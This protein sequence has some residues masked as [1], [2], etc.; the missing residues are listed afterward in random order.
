MAHIEKQIAVDASLVRSDDM[1]FLRVQGDGMI[2]AHIMDGDLALIRPREMVEQGAI[3][4]VLIGDEATI[5]YFFKERDGIRLQP[6]NPSQEPL[7]I[8]KKMDEVRVIDKV[9]GI[10]RG[11]ER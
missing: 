10:V 5:K 7:R 4:A 3:A 6:T 1:F 9:V 8:S 11:M 2:E